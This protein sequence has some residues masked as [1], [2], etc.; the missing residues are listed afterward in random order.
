MS[1]RNPDC[2]NSCSATI[3]DWTDQPTTRCANDCENRPMCGF[4]LDG[5]EFRKINRPSGARVERPDTGPI[6]SPIPPHKKTRSH[7]RAVVGCGLCGL[8]LFDQFIFWSDM[9]GQ[10]FLPVVRVVLNFIHE[11]GRYIL[12]PIFSLLPCPN[13]LYRPFKKTDRFCPPQS[14]WL[15]I[16]IIGYG[17]FIVPGLILHLCCVIGA[18]L[19]DPYH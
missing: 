10:S 7:C 19:G 14:A 6:Q 18:G 3:T 4:W 2:S 15:L 8:L 11:P 12:R 13:G 1:G 16:T 9:V 5:L 17:C